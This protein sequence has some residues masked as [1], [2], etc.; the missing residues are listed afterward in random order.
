M[1]S[2]KRSSKKHFLETES[3]FKRLLKA[4]RNDVPSEKTLAG[5][6][7]FNIRTGKID[8]SKLPVGIPGTAAFYLTSLLDAEQKSSDELSKELGVTVQDVKHLQKEM[9][10]IQEK[11]LFEFCGKFV[12][13]HP[14]F[15][16]RPLYSTLKR[17]IVLHAMSSTEA[18]VKRAARKKPPK[19]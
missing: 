16:L 5:I 2:D 10:P 3:G 14:Q 6:R 7:D 18:L 15:S 9:N 4:A 11:S 17:A 8:V 19:K 13:K 1:S 12:D